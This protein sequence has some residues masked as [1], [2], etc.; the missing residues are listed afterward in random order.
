MARSLRNPTA[1]HVLMA[2][3]A[4]FGMPA[5]AQPAVSRPRR[6]TT[7]ESARTPPSRQPCAY[8]AKQRARKRARRAR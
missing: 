7:G 2:A 4:A 3:F 5:G 1:L 8:A 6:T